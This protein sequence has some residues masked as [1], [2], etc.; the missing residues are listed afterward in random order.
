M[1]TVSAILRAS[2]ERDW[3]SRTP[4]FSLGRFD[5]F[6]QKDSCRSQPRSPDGVPSQVG[7]GSLRSPETASTSF[8]SSCSFVTLAPGGAVDDGIVL[9]IASKAEVTGLKPGRSSRSLWLNSLAL[10]TVS[11]GL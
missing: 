9:P 11:V 2:P 5:S 8:A 6:S 7:M 3:K 4:H 10:V 1:L